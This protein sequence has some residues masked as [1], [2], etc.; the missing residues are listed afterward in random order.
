M[1]AGLFS[2]CTRLLLARALVQADTVSHLLAS[3]VVFAYATGMVVRAAVRPLLAGTQ[4][5]AIL[6]APTTVAAT[7]IGTESSA[8]YAALLV[9]EILL[10]VGALQLIAFLY[11]TILERLLARRDLRLAKEAAEEAQRRAE[12]ASVA[13]S[14]FLATMSHEIRTPLNGIMGLTDL[15]LDRYLLDPELRRQVEL[16]KVSG[17]ALLTVVNDVLDF[18]KLEAGAVELDVKPFWPKAMVETCAAMVRGLAAQKNLELIVSTGDTL[19]TG[20]SAT[21]QGCDKCC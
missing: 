11:N 12:Q 21:R 14:D 19:R 1:A 17:E 5:L 10:L 13:K 16:V 6:V 9:I 15:I 18:S 3:L 7:Y 8:Y 2:V 20:L 4:V